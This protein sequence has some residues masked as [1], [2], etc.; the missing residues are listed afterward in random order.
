[1]IEQP[2]DTSPIDVVYLQAAGPGGGGGGSPQ[3]AAPATPQL[4]HPRPPDPVPVVEPAVLSQPPVP[5]LDVP[6]MTSMNDLLRANGQSG[7]NLA[8]FGGGG[9][10]NG[11]GPGRGSGL[12]DGDG[13]NTGGGPVRPGNGCTDPVAVHEVR[14][15]F[16]SDAMR[17]KIQGNVRME[18][19]VRKD[20]TV[21]DVRIVSSLDRTFGLDESAVKAAKSW[22]F[23]PATC[24]GT[25]VDMIV[26]IELEFRLH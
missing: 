20:G 26:T 16:T 12:G 5:S 1:V 7:V 23:H 2:V 8:A 15:L 13:G 4:P 19:V 22:L 3:P 10:G 24:K 11:D 18:V 9:R 17:A 14:P 6:A 25:A 21:G